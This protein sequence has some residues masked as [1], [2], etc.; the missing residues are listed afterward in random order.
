MR[1]D[2]S[3]IH[4]EPLVCTTCK[5]PFR[6]ATK[7]PY[8]KINGGQKLFVC[9]SCVDNWRKHWTSATIEIMPVDKFTGDKLA[10]V[11]FTDGSKQIIHYGSIGGEYDSVTLDAPIEFFDN[12]GKLDKAYYSEVNKGIVADATFEESFEEN[13]CTVIFKDGHN[14]RLHYKYGRGGCLLLDPVETTGAKVTEEQLRV[15]N[16]LF[17]QNN[18]KESEVVNYGFNPYQI[19]M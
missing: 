3:A 10:M 13:L 17:Q 4:T 11:N 5:K 7:E 19:G 9:D 14:L 6:P 18:N 12:L 1:N 16:G 8:C 15:I 2:K